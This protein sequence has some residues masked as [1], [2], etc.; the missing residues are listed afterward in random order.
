MR[1]VS[2]L[3]ATGML[4][5]GAVMAAAIVDDEGATAASQQTPRTVS[6][7]ASRSDTRE[8]TPP[9]GPADGDGLRWRA[10]AGRDTATR[11]PAPQP[12]AAAAEADDEAT[13]PALPV[14]TPDLSSVDR[15][16][17]V[18]A[19]EVDVPSPA[20]PSDGPSDRPSDQPSDRPSDEPSDQP[21][22]SPS[23]EPADRTPEHHAPPPDR[24][25]PQTAIDS[26]PSNHDDSRARFTFHA[27][28]QSSF[29][30]SLDGGGFSSCQSGVRYTHLQ[31]GW[32][33]F[34]VRAT[35]SA[36][37]A[38]GSPAGYQW[39]TSAVRWAKDQVEDQ[40]GDLLQH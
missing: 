33:S 19:P 20:R 4:L 22:E 17:R 18:A 27:S 38:D 32:H 9:A 6:P 34:A 5:G 8:P 37:N 7:G 10:A 35:D 31:P 26:G 3:A 1:L 2:A 25:A 30:C 28:E 23:P 36:G 13:Q 15:S 39:H 21:T 29:V 12:A 24:T 40:V 14:A 11:E 16:P